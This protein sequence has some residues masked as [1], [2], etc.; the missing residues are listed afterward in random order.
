MKRLYEEPEFDLVH[1]RFESLLAKQDISN[2]ENKGSGGE[3]IE[4]DI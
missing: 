1:F 4:G 2:P 3:E